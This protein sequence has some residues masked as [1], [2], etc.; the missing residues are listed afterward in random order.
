MFIRAA[1]QYDAK[2]LSELV[3]KSAKECRAI[4][5]DDYGWDLFLSVN[6]L[7]ALSSRI[8]NNDYLILCN[9]VDNTISG[10]ISILNNEKIDPLFV[11]P[12]Y[13][14]IG[15]ASTLWKSAYSICSQSKSNQY[16]WVRSS[17]KAVPVNKSF[18]F[19][20]TEPL[21]IRNGI[22]FTLLSKN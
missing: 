12:N 21:Q 14:N 17:T 4:D 16:Y 18:G 11:S 10:M 1:Q 5:F 8:E 19:E 9:I 15:I 7:T 13:R 20:I 3:E 2:E 22:S 6:T